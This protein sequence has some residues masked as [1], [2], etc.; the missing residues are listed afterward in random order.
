MC[1]HV[2]VC[3]CVCT[4]FFFPIRQGNSATSLVLLLLKVF[5][6]GQLSGAQFWLRGQHLLR[7]CLGC[8]L[9]ETRPLGM[10]I[11]L[12][13]PPPWD[14][15]PGGSDDLNPHRALHGGCLQTPLLPRLPGRRAPG[16]QRL[17]LQP[18][19]LLRS[20]LAQPRTYFK[21]NLELVVDS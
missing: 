15:P 3:V 12:G 7:L 10:G 17:A 9:C 16:I 11:S 4:H 2:C 20:Y 14:L 5:S 8:T 21:N 13:V 19:S 18:W 1:I 6:L